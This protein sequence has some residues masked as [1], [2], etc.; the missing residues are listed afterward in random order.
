MEHMDDETGSGFP[1]YLLIS[2]K[3]S[4]ALHWGKFSTPTDADI[5]GA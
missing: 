5:S 2:A 1:E 3:V 4:A